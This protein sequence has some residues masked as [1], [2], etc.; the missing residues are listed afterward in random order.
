MSR[1]TLT[2]RTL[3]AACLALVGTLP[4][5]ALAAPPELI[6]TRFAESLASHCCGDNWLNIQQAGGAALLYSVNSWG[7]S[8]GH[9]KGDA[10]TFGTLGGAGSAGAQ[11]HRAN[12]WTG[13][14]GAARLRDAWSD[15][16][17]I[18][19]GALPAGTPVALRLTVVLD[20]TLQVPST[21]G[22]ARAAANFAQAGWDAP[23]ITGVELRMG[24][25]GGQPPGLLSGSHSNSAEVGSF[26]G[27]SLHLIGQLGLSANYAAPAGVSSAYAGAQVAG[28]ARYFVDL[29]T[30]GASLSTAS[31]FDY[32]TPVPEPAAAALWLA[33]LLA[34]GWRLR[35]RC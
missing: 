19:S 28:Q 13:S 16:F 10:A 7:Q 9:V 3:A 14:G 2:T 1:P 23:W 6:Q 8:H 21:A 5:V 12:G 30:P 26:V 4:A 35:R 31:G 25:S 29:L 11:L 34:L 27:S 32:A 15:L 24:G 33:G 18:T 22:S 17:T 20:A